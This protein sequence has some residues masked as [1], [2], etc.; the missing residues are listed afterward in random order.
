MSFPPGQE[1]FAAGSTTCAP[2]PC[3]TTQFHPANLANT[4][5]PSQTIAGGP[6]AGAVD[7]GGTY[8]LEVKYLTIAEANNSIDAVGLTYPIRPSVLPGH[9]VHPRGAPTWRS[10]EAPAP[11]PTAAG[12][13]RTRT[14]QTLVRASSTS[15]WAGGIV[16]GAGTPP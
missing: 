8:T 16:A 1:T 2:T 10:S 13:T 7:P 4:T 9:R 6:F 15:P 3:D 12:N 14:I 5:V 11:P